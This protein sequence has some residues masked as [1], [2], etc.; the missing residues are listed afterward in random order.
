MTLE[1]GERRTPIDVGMKK[2]TIRR[3]KIDPFTFDGTLDA[4][5][6][7]DWRTNLDYYFGWY[8]FT[9]ESRVQ[10]ARMRLLE[11]ARIYWTLVER[12]H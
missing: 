8:R 2:M 7:S 6:F 9:E 3:I 4:K 5:I 12:V 11:S 10:F 1:I